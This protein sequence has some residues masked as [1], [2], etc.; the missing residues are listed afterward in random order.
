VP[1]TRKE[2]TETHAFSNQAQGERWRQGDHSLNKMMIQMAPG[3][4]LTRGEIGQPR[5]C[6]EEKDGWAGA[7]FNTRV[8]EEEN[9]LLAK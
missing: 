9:P 6:P 5:E 7:L 4:K 8:P 3:E 2:R 1:P